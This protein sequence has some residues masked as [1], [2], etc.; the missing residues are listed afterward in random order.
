MRQ[1]A[2]SIGLLGALL[3]LPHR[4]AAEAAC[5]PS[6]L[7]N[8]YIVD[9][10]S[11]FF[12]VDYLPEKGIL[13]R[14]GVPWPLAGLVASLLQGLTTTIDPDQP[15]APIA[16]ID[17]GP[18]EAAGLDELRDY[19]NDELLDGMAMT[20]FS[21]Q[22]LKPSLR[23]AIVRIRMV[24]AVANDPSLETDPIAWDAKEEEIE[25]Q[26][27]DKTTDELVLELTYLTLLRGSDGPESLYSDPS[28]AHARVLGVLHTLTVLMSPE[29][30]IVD[31]ARQDF[32]E[33]DVFVHHMM[34]MERP[35]D[36]V[37]P[38]AFA[39]QIEHAKWLD[40]HYNNNPSVND[41]QQLQLAFV[42]AYDPFR[43][44][45][46]LVWQGAAAGA[47]GIKFYPP[48]GS[49]PADTTIPD[50]PSPTFPMTASCAQRE[51]W[52][53]RYDDWAAADIDAQ[54]KAVFA[55]AVTR[56]LPVFSHHNKS[57]FPVGDTYKQTDYGKLMGAPCHWQKILDGPNPPTVILAHAGGT[58]A[59]FN[60]HADGWS[61]PYSL[62]AYNLCVSYPTVYC[63]FGGASRIL[64]AAKRAGFVDRLAHLTS[65]AAT[66]TP[67]APGDL[68][69]LAGEVP[70]QNYE[71]ED[72]IL[73]GSD[74]LVSV[75]P[76]RADYLCRFG[77]AFGPGSSLAGHR[78]K[79][80]GEN[81]RSVFG[82]P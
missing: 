15:D 30:T 8:L 66:A 18:L 68:C 42:V 67:Q 76:D 80:F 71:L 48:S 57:G 45:A 56:G 39:D 47:R 44:D 4:A 65:L 63:D 53:A 13:Y 38:L 82:L 62:Q 9:A 54:N 77:E 43:R 46:G 10:H 7:A 64:D 35:Y 1:V 79:F 6:G 81:A 26:Y 58:G 17:L 51:Q 22:L 78:V 16:T 74:W 37:P 12:N 14:Y 60:R 21:I 70:V 33:V 34:D 72:K 27:E 23:K 73:Y 32:P 50:K 36:D 19:V 61:D 69:A 3:L 52:D 59:W 28:Q 2:I 55:E 11:H 40:A 75:E 49:R 25:D 41:P 29:T 24:E 31:R 20:S 5:D